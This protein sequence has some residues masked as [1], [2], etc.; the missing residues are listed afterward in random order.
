MADKQE[1]EIVIAP[2]GKVSIRVRCVKGAAC[3]ELTRP[4]QEALGQVVGQER[5]DEYYEATEAEAA[6][7]RRKS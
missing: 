6:R 2:D 4:I 3:E 7:V 5:T 1:L